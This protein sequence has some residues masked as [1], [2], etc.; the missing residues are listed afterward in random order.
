VFPIRRFLLIIVR[1][2]ELRR[3]LVIPTLKPFVSYWTVSLGPPKV[4][5]IFTS[6]FVVVFL[7]SFVPELSVVLR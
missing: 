5:L 2:R 4:L 6:C 7:N 3:R 1:V